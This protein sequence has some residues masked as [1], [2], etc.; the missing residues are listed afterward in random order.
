[1]AYRRFS[2]IASLL[3]VAALLGSGCGDRAPAG[4]TT[5]PGDPRVAVAPTTAPATT[6]P[7]EPVSTI[8]PL[9][10][11]ELPDLGAEVRIPDGEG[12]FPA[13][14]LVHGGGWVGGTPS[15]MSDLALHLT[16]EGFLTVNARY[17]LA[18]SRAPGFPAALDDLACA[19]RYA[20][21]HP[22][23]DGTV[24]LVGYSAGA[25]L[26]AVVALT[27]ERY[28]ADCPVGGSGIPSRF[29]GLA[30]PYDVSRIG[31]AA[32]P[33]FGGGPQAAAEA[34]AAGN[35]QLLTDDNPGLVSLLLHGENDGI[36]DFTHA[37]EFQRALAESGSGALL[38]IVEGARHRDLHDPAFVGDLIVT[39][40]ER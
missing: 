35:P 10:I 29:V 17:H 18:A 1:M 23:A 38:E 22:R 37:V 12:R 27:G 5:I 30:G 11:E 26:G 8:P 14:V 4:E 2:R 34:W 40:L 36:V 15:I 39:W 31:I 9:S 25:H 20:A 24:A 32:V 28:G 6:T 33:F 19:V 7:P 16:A 13:V 3:A 21:A